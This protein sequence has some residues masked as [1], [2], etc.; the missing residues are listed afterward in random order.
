MKAGRNGKCDG[1]ENAHGPADERGNEHCPCSASEAPHQHA[2]VDE[3]EQE[4]HYLHRIPERV[5]EVSGRLVR[6]A[7][8]IEHAVELS[9]GMRQEGDNGQQR[10]RR[11]HT[12]PEARYPGQCAAD[13][14]VGTE[15]PHAGAPQKSGGPNCR[16]QQGERRRVH[17][18]NGIALRDEHEADGVGGNDQQQKGHR[19]VPAKDALGK[20]EAHDYVDCARNWPAK[21]Q[22][23]LVGEADVQR[24][25]RYGS[26]NSPGGCDDGEYGAAPGVQRSAR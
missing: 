4:R 10:E 3:P 24:E 19:R 21:G 15:R 16:H 26:E 9:R 12:A 20:H 25:D 5:L 18:G 6:P 8:L 14:Q 7:R 22:H 17:L 1:E 11:M 2:A 23:R 13:Q